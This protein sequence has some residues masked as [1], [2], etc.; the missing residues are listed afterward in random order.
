MHFYQ[1]GN[2]PDVSKGTLVIIYLVED[3]RDNCWEAKIIEQK[4]R[5]IKLSINSPPSAAIG[6]Y[7]LSVITQ[8]LVDGT[9]STY[10]SENDIYMLF[11]P[12]CEGTRGQDTLKIDQLCSSSYMYCFSPRW[13]CVHG[14]C[15]TEERIRVEWH[16]F[17]LLRDREPDRR[18][19]VEFWTGESKP[20]STN[21]LQNSTDGLWCSLSWRLICNHNWSNQ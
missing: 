1:T 12:W 13:L 3:L 17:N 10:C 16:G 20:Y 6:K 9:M 21:N 4:G 8:S 14:W 5:K 18:Q 19:S 15:W 7:K 2:H 11:N